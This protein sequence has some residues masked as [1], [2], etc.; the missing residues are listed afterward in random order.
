MANAESVQKLLKTVIPKHV[1]MPLDP[2]CSEAL[3]G[4][5][6]TEPDARNKATMEKL[7]PIVAKYVETTAA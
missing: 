1:E 7:G 4:A 3:N 6:F 5:I 2:E